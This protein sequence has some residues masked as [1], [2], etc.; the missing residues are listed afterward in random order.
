MD[1]ER[2][3]SALRD[4]GSSES[5]SETAR[6]REVFHD[7]EAALAAGVS[8]NAILETLHEQGFKMTLKS[9]ESALYRLRKKA[10]AGKDGIAKPVSPISAP[11]PASIPAGQEKIAL[12]TSE[13][14]ADE[15]TNNLPLTA[16][17]KRERRANQFIK[18]ESTNPLLKSLKGN[19]K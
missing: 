7:I 4:L 15:D 3:A 9:F 11:A 12:D 13:K 1:K 8:R 10:A 17:E 16:R 18:P 14:P 19:Q 5:R 6:L 2:V